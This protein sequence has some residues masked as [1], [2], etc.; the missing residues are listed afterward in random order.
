MR[1]LFEG[2]IALVLGLAVFS[3]A[4]AHT[5]PSTIKGPSPFKIAGSKA[6]GLLLAPPVVPPVQEPT[7]SGQKQLADAV[8]KAA[9]I[10]DA[11]L[12]VLRVTTR[13][14]GGRTIATAVI[15]C[16]PLRGFNGA[17]TLSFTRLLLRAPTNPEAARNSGPI[18][19]VE[20][21]AS[22]PVP[23][24]RPGELT[25]MEADVT[26]LLGTTI[27]VSLSPGDRNPANDSKTVRV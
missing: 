19:F 11:D 23:R 2:T 3:A 1:W 8:N 10:P 17:R 25:V 18:P 7:V 16:D 12:S 22:F 20:V 24:L 6:A 21:I 4:R 15:Q 13:Q 9:P 27:T 14:E 5:P 26:S